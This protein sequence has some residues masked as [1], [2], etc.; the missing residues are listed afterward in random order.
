[1]DILEYIDRVKANFDKQPE[2]RY[3]TKKYFMGGLATPKRGLVDGPGS[4]NGDIVRKAGDVGSIREVFSKIDP[5][6]VVGYVVDIK[7]PGKGG[8][9]PD[10]GKTYY[11]IKEFGNIKNAKAEAN[12]KY[13]EVIQRKEFR[14]LRGDKQL[15][16]REEVVK[17]FLNYL[18]NNEFDGYEKLE[19]E[20]EKYKGSDGRFEQ[21]N[22][23]FKDWKEGKFEVEGIDR[24]NLSKEARIEIKNW[25][26]KPRGDRT[27]VRRNELRFLN[28]LNN[29]Q[30]ISL[31]EV[32]AQFKKQFGKGKYY[33]NITFNSRIQDLTKIKRE[34]SFG[35]KRLT[36]GIGAGERAFWLKKALSE[37]ISFGSNY[38]R[39]IRA[40][41]VLESKGKTR[42]AKRLYSVADTFF[43]SNGV[44]TKLPGQAE[45]PLSVTYGGTDN[46][47][48]VDSLVKGDLNQLKRVIFDTPLKKLRSEY[49]KSGTTPRR[50]NEIKNLLE[51]R[52][53][54]MNYLTSGSF[55]KGIVQSVNFNFTPTEVTFTSSVK[56]V[57]K[58]GKNYDFGT[59]VK[60]GEEYSKVFA[61]KGKEFNLITKG[62][63]AK[64]TAVS[65]KKLANV[66]AKAGFRCGAAE[67]LTCDKP[68]A[69]FKDI[70]I[71]TER[72]KKGQPDAIKKFEN[73][74]NV[75]RKSKALLK[76]TGLGVLAEAGFE[77]AFVLNDIFSGMPVKEAFQ[78]SLFQYVFPKLGKT[79]DAETSKT[80][81]IVGDDPRSQ[82]YVKD[83]AS[84]DKLMSLYNRYEETDSDVVDAY[85]QE[86][87]FKA[88]EDLKNFV[89]NFDPKTFERTKFG[90]PE[91]QAFAAKEEVED[92]NKIKR[93]MDIDPF[94]FDRNVRR[95]S[96][97]LFG[98]IKA[99]QIGRIPI[100]DKLSQIA[101]YGG[102][103]KLASGGIA[104]G[105]PPKKG[106]QSQ[107]LAYLMK[108]GKR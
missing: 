2:P 83:L 82:Q 56:P 104:S 20:L 95:T 49:N 29:N 43:G 45:H 31:A 98:D 106:P 70:K 107:G 35:D 103:S 11:G 79:R 101:A 25:S 22:K 84:V 23:D 105:P 52:K 14:N 60:K 16:R 80:Q 62:G 66:L 12:K 71:Q 92:V 94:M 59:F 73:A 36:A 5:T 93:A 21:I 39:V 3:N 78:R 27:L 33:S 54:F 1:M 42:E 58:L 10:I 76:A 8:A 15:V 24:K 88:E 18:E 26:P 51:N 47:L 87:K 99:K 90:S 65:D 89:D 97:P 86:E 40:A 50:R 6:E 81:R 69:Y 108:N 85:T 55:D 100:E 74:G 7:S 34:G 63:F 77:G 53:S 4:Y 91:Q 28:E 48:K 37:N 61:E 67:G 96:T 72:A 44:L 32:K 30:D 9:R 38:S 64:R 57:D 41:D 13:N 46:L 68:E 102:V 19:P 17:T 75:A